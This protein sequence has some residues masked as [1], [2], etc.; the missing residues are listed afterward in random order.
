MTDLTKVFANVQEFEGDVYVADY[1]NQTHSARGVVI[2]GE[3]FDDIASFHLHNSDGFP[4][5]A[6]NFEENKGFFPEGVSDCECM[7]RVK[8]VEKGWWLLCEL[9]YCLDKNIETNAD[10]A[11][12]QLVET[13]Q[14]LVDRKVLNKRRG[15]TY[16]N[17]SIPDHS[18]RTPFVSFTA[19][20]DDQIRWRKKNRIH[21]L[22]HNEVLVINAGIL[23]VPQV[24]M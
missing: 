14:L 21:L 10:T 15:K 23:M 19:T 12:A 1:T 3:P 4:L 18:Y 9:K 24:A 13:W 22:G 5:L 16:L 20:Q 11:Y 6:V 8:N 17:I 2:L 7:L